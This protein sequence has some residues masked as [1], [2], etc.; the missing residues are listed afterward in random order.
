MKDLSLAMRLNPSYTDLRPM[1][2]SNM[3]RA[4]QFD[5]A[6]A[7]YHTL[8]SDPKAAGAAYNMLFEY[9]AVAHAGKDGSATLAE[10]QAKLPSRDWPYPIFE[11]FLGRMD[12][13]ALLKDASTERQV[14]RGEVP[15]RREDAVGRQQAACRCMVSGR[16]QALLGRARGAVAVCLVRALKRR[17]VNPRHRYARPNRYWQLTRISAKPSASAENTIS[18]QVVPARLAKPVSVITPAPSTTTLSPV[19]ALT[20]T[21][22][23]VWQMA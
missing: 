3:F 5:A 6:A 10:G 16:R 21:T 12:E 14:L 13:R 2:A 7:E 22:A 11:Y 18:V 19:M 9:V 17:A 15:C 20:R 23:G 1:L 8:A 4:R